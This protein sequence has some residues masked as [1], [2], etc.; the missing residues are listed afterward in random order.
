MKAT[1]TNIRSQLRDGFSRDRTLDG[2]AL[3]CDSL[4]EGVGMKHIYHIFSER[5]TVRSKGAQPARLAEIQS[6]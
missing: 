5:A 6:E 3:V 2:S 4:T 1:G